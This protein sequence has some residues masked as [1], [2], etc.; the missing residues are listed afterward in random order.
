M[1]QHGVSTGSPAVRAR[2][3]AAAFAERSVLVPVVRSFEQESQAPI[4]NDN[5]NGR[6]RD[7]AVNR[8][9]KGIQTLQ[10]CSKTEVVPSPAGKVRR[11]RAGD[12]T[13]STHN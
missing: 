5:D 10:I 7:S 11:L 12:K 9:A 1:K 4:G 2:P 13:C 6:G 3:S 8:K